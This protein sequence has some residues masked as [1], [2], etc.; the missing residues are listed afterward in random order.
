MYAP[1]GSV[2]FNTYET[3]QN[4]RIVADTI[5]FNGSIFNI[6]GQSED[7]ELI[8]GGNTPV[9]EDVAISA[10]VPK[11]VP[12]AAVINIPIININD[13]EGLTYSAVFDGKNME[14]ED[15]VIKLAVP[16]IQGEYV[17]TVSADA[18]N[19][20]HDSVS[21]DI[22]VDTAA[23]LVKIDANRTFAY[24]NSDDIS[25]KVTA[26]DDCALRNVLIYINGEKTEYEQ[27]EEFFI[28]TT[29]AGVYTIRAEAIDEAGN[30]SVTE[31]VITVAEDI[32]DKEPPTVSLVF[33]K[34]VYCV[35]ETA[36][37]TA[38]AEDNVAVDRVELLY[39]GSVYTFGDNNTLTVANLAEGE[40]V[41]AV[42]AYD[43]SDNRVTMIYT[44]VVGGVP[45][46]THPEVTI[47]SI[48]PSKIYV[49]DTV[50][51]T[52][53]AYDESG[54]SEI[55]ATINGISVP[56]V[57]GTITY[58]PTEVGSYSITIM[59]ADIYGNTNTA[60][61]SFEVREQ[62]VPDTEAPRITANVSVYGENPVVNNPFIITVD[63]EDNSGSAEV[64]VRINGQEI[65]G[66]N[67]EYIFVPETAGNYTIEISA[68]DPSGNSASCSYTIYVGEDTQIDEIPPVLSA[69]FENL[70]VQIGDVIRIS[71][72]ATDNKSEAHVSAE[73]NG[74]LIPITNGVI[75]YVPET[76]GDYL[77]VIT[78]TD[79][80]GNV[81]S[82]SQNIKVVEKIEDTTPPTLVVNG[83]PSRIVLGE[84]IE[85]QIDI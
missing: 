85:A 75:E 16:D 72:E 3:T 61:V 22:I 15:G 27:N 47:E 17:L 66:T 6:N 31:I 32:I 13:I 49:D 78:A 69:T 71:V 50:I 24:T 8:G 14:I 83:I 28:S 48:T 73:V 10:D 5:N 68:A 51:I 19:G 43:T 58:I 65:S 62:V 54:I 80:A 82:I 1:N 44:I 34:D 42:T 77:F 23:P 76:I 60:T 55:T 67:N 2:N 29:E 84:V 33:D 12:A 21:Y 64:T 20:G 11:Y 57:N 46:I 81:S 4:G 59:A 37:I 53:S 39:N 56:V 9:K 40:N 45:D 7:W 26:E 79:D 70:V 36:V 52:V 38:R 41:F 25:V 18:P 30:I 35:G 74:V 63:A